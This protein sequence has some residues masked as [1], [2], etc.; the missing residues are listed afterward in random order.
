MTENDISLMKNY[1]EDVLEQI[2]E[3]VKTIPK[4]E[5][6]LHDV[7]FDLKSTFL[8]SLEKIDKIT[9]LV[10]LLSMLDLLTS[11]LL[12]QSDPIELDYTLK[13]E[14]IAIHIFRKLINV[15][16][17]FQYCEEKKR[18]H[19]LLYSKQ[20]N[21]KILFMKKSNEYQ[22]QLCSFTVTFESLDNV[23]L[24]CDEIIK[25]IKDEWGL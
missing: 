4:I 15:C 9:G 1:I 11:L 7:D 17:H 23:Y 18:F 5:F 12:N 24:N 13:D 19:A 2:T 8:K 25:M 3:R 6:S 14:I 16:Y 20:S 22:H 21:D 10:T